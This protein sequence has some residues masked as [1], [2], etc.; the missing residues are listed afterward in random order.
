MRTN[1]LDL[2]VYSVL[3]LVIAA[4]VTFGGCRTAS[5]QGAKRP[6]AKAHVVKAAGKTMVC[7]AVTKTLTVCSLR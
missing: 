4:F 2:C 6:A 3:A 7:V 5:A 1:A